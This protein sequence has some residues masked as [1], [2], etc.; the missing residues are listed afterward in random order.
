MTGCMTSDDCHALLVAASTVG[1][2]VNARTWGALLEAVPDSAASDVLLDRRVSDDARA[3]LLRRAL[4]GHTMR[5]HAAV[6]LL[7][8]EPSVAATAVDGEV[9]HEIATL[10]TVTSHLAAPVIASTTGAALDSEDLWSFLR[11]LPIGLAR[12]AARGYFDRHRELPR[13]QALGDLVTQ[14]VALRVETDLKDLGSDPRL[15][16]D[17]MDLL[18]ATGE[19]APSLLAVI[20]H[21]LPNMS[22]RLRRTRAG[23]IART[24]REL[25]AGASTAIGDIALR[26]VLDGLTD[27][28]SLQPDELELKYAVV[29]ER[30]APR[31]AAPWIVWGARRRD[32]QTESHPHICL[33]ISWVGR[34]VAAGDLPIGL[35]TASLTDRSLDSSIRVARS[36]LSRSEHAWATT[37]VARYGARSARW[38]SRLKA[39]SVP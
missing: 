32:T 25:A 23:A 34:H 6:N 36:Q 38:W 27:P 5:P 11:E 26:L 1:I 9:A 31:A 12:D 10:L 15:T 7:S 18:D 21:E 30:V 14:S 28:S 20:G 33:A 16:S 19:G 13:S 8:M 35:V 24:A 2:D 4:L 37:E 29:C 39:S 17:E 3:Q 22:S